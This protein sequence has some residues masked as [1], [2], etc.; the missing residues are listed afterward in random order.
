M[1]YLQRYSP[2]ELCDGAYMVIF[3]CP[4]LTASRLQHISDLHS[5]FTL[6]PHYVWKYGTHPIC[7]G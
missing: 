4:V 3:L 2:T 5:K 6:G 1:P 7:D